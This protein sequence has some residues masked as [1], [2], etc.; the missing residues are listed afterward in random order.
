MVLHRGKKHA[1]LGRKTAKTHTKYATRARG[2]VSAAPPL[3]KG[4]IA[5]HKAERHK[6]ISGY[7]REEDK[8]NA[9]LPGHLTL[10]RAVA[11]YS[12]VRTIVNF[13]LAC[14]DRGKMCVIQPMVNEDAGSNKIT[15]TNCIGWVSDTDQSSGPVPTTNTPLGINMPSVGN[16]GVECVPAAISVRI[17]CPSPLIAATGQLFLGR[18]NMPADR[19]NYVHYDDME[20]G[21]LA[22]AKPEPYTAAM[23]A[24]CT[25][26][27]S[28]IPRDFNDYCEFHNYEDTNFTDALKPWGGMT[29]ILYCL[30]PV[31][32]GNVTQY[33]LQICVEWRYRFKMDDPAA[34]SHEFHFPHP[35]DKVNGL[36]AR[37]SGKPGVDV[38]KKGDKSPPDVLTK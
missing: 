37:M 12:V 20:K 17:T 29:P 27:V 18:W 31:S 34:S 32:G 13:P 23:M 7:R 24:T 30:S 1:A 2:V 38:V 16:T 26:Q 9:F 14:S 6:V 21:F 33:N 36:I 5:R 19:K 15:F 11:P 8:L 35:I 22:F 3:T 25:R 10:P 28:A 4:G